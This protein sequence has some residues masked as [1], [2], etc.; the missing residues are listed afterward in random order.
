MFSIRK[1]HRAQVLYF[2]NPS[3]DEIVRAIDSKSE[4]ASVMASYLQQRFQKRTIE[5]LE[6]TDLGSELDAL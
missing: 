5:T 4:A 3:H 1:K 2:H 6:N